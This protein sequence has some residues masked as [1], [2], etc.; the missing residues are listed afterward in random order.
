MHIDSEHRRPIFINH[1]VVLTA[2]L[3]LQLAAIHL[4]DSASF[5]FIFVYYLESPKS[6]GPSQLLTYLIASKDRRY[7]VYYGR[8]SGAGVVVEPAA[9]RS[10]A[11]RRI[12][13]H[14]FKGD[15]RA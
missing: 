4:P 5:S 1:N 2:V 6:G 14:L 3:Y 12:K 13:R 15:E 10:S 7:W 11:L 8:A 9:E